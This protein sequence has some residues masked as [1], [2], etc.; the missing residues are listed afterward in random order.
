M[1]ANPTRREL[2]KAAVAGA[3]TAAIDPLAPIARAMELAGAGGNGDQ[4][5]APRG[6]ATAARPQ[7][8]RFVHFT[9]IHLTTERHGD[10]GFAAALKAAGALKPKPDFILTG[11][12]LIWDALEVDREKA[13]AQF[14][15]FKKVLADHI[16]L[17][18]Y[19]TIGNHD[20]LGWSEKSGL[21]PDAAGYGK[22]LYCDELGLPRTWHTFAHKGW[23]FFCLDNL[24]PGGTTRYPYQGFVDGEQFDWLKAEFGATDPATPIIT[25]EHI[26][27]VSATPYGHDHLIDGIHWKLQ[28][29]LI[30]SD[31]PKRLPLYQTRNVQLCLSGHIHERDRCELNGITF[32]NDGAVCAKWWKGPHRGVEEGFGIID[33]RPDGTFLHQYFDYGW[34]AVETDSQP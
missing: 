33:V 20:I 4:T 11:G 28:N 21:K 18:A 9:D 2:L 12:D 22:A 30:C 24:Q 26:P 23:R 10:K 25:C 34:Q 16:D 14:A 19:H 7:A 17:P 13:R 31:G 3:A 6:S 15:L 32:I 8:F 27:T 5:G 1:P 29:S